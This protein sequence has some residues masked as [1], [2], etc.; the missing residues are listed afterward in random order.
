MNS[1]VALVA[2][3]SRG[4]GLLIARELLDRGH[5]VAICARD[6][7]EVDRAAALLTDHGPVR[8]YVCDIGSR[9]DVAVLVTRVGQDLGPIEV[10]ISVAGVIQVGPAESM[11]LE[12]FDEA[13]ATMLHGPVQ[14][15]WAVLPGMRARKRGRIATITSVGGTLA[16]PHLLP[17]ATAKFGAVGFSEGLSAELRGSGVTATTV[18]PGL[19][20]TGSHEQA[21]FTGDQGAEYAWFA[22]AASLPLL[23]M[24][25]ERAAAKIVDG[26]LRGRSHVVLSPLAKVG[27]RVHGLAPASTVGMLGLVSR[28]LPAAPDPAS[29]QTPTIVG[30]QAQRVLDSRTVRVLTTLGSRSARRFNERFARSG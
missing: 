19:M 13:I 17:Y 10:L 3:A 22:P 26:V 4:L 20:R 25:A 7:G 14:L 16:P 5:T 29:A 18:I 11:T 15:T 8:A 27:M 23:S 9:D 24:N 21:M 30:H 12:H 28:L 1:P 6:R 2:G